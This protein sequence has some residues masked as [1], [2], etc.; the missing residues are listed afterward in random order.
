MNN[1]YIT[2]VSAN[3][4]PIK[5]EQIGNRQFTR[6]IRMAHQHMERCSSVTRISKRQIKMRQFYINRKQNSNR[7]IIAIIGE[8]VEK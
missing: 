8:G 3:V 4:N 7:L 2:Y 6:E 5:N 1:A